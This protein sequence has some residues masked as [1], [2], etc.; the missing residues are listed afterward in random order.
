LK[1]FRSHFHPPFLDFSWRYR[2]ELPPPHRSCL[3]AAVRA[4]YRRQGCMGTD[5]STWRI[6]PFGRLWQARHPPRYAAF[7]R[8]SPPRFRL[9]SRAGGGQP[10]GR[11][12]EAY[13]PFRV[14]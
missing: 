6:A 4:A 8:L 14:R 11:S 1:G 7:N 12:Q 9:S 5:L 3:R 2:D 10:F 13:R